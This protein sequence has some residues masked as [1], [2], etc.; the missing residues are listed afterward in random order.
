MPDLSQNVEE[1][2][3]YVNEDNHTSLQGY[4][5]NGNCMCRITFT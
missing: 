5:K 3:N 1:I 2:F 4:N